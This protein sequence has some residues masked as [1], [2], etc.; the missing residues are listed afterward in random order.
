MNPAQQLS[1][2]K[3]ISLVTF[4]KD[5]TA[6]PTPVWFA[7]RDGKLYVMTRNDMWKYKRIRNKPEVRVAAC[8][9]RG[10]VTGPEV[11]GRARILPRE[12][13]KATHELI[14]RKYWLARFP[15][16]SPKNEFIEIELSI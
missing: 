3:Y 15:F 10:K 8:N 11:S 13:W 5:G 14:K 1:S 7:E 12:E 2:E 9:F 4:K 6:V 16:S